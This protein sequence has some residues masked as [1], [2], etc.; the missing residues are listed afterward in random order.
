M[1]SAATQRFNICPTLKTLKVAPF[2]PRPST[3]ALLKWTTSWSENIE[4]LDLRLDYVADFLR[5]VSAGGHS[6]GITAWP[7][8]QL[9]CLSGRYFPEPEFYGVSHADLPTIIDLYH[10]NG[11]E[12]LTDALGA[13][14][15]A[16]ASLPCIREIR[17]KLRATAQPTIMINLSLRNGASKLTFFAEP[18]VRRRRNTPTVSFLPPI[19]Q[20]PTRLPF[21]HRMLP[22]KYDLSDL[23]PQDTIRPAIAGVRSAILTHFG[24]DLEV[25]WPKKD[26]EPESQQIDIVE[27]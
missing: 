14:A 1:T 27:N 26:D 6:A 3:S 16:L 11:G 20:S 21:R 8:L 19:T 10:W 9:L 4:H 17:I 18:A 22:I 2:D 5:T 23:F 24:L 7:K 13:M 12:A 25:V 15:T